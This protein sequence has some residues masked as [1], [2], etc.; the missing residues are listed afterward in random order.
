MKTKKTRNILIGA[1]VVLSTALMYVAWR[2]A[3]EPPPSASHIALMSQLAEQGQ[4]EHPDLIVYDGTNA[5]EDPFVTKEQLVEMG[6][7]VLQKDQKKKTG[8]GDLSKE[9]EEEI[10]KKLT[11]LHNEFVKKDGR[12]PRLSEVSFKYNEEYVLADYHGP[13]TVEALMAEF[14]EYYSHT[15]SSPGSE[16]DMLFPRDE[17]IQRALDL[18]VV[19]LDNYDYAGIMQVRGLIAWVQSDPKQ[20]ARLY[21]AKGL[22]DEANFNAYIDEK[23]KDEALNNILWRDAMRK[24]PNSTGGFRLGNRYV[25]TRDNHMHVK[26]MPGDP[27]HTVFMLGPRKRDLTDEEMHLLKY[28][29]VAPEDIEVFYID[30]NNEVMPPDSEPMRLDWKDRI[31]AMPEHKRQEEF[32]K[33]VEFLNSDMVNQMTIVDWMT[34][35]DYTGALLNYTD[36]GRAGV[37]DAPPVPPAPSGVAA[38][39]EGQA[40][41]PSEQELPRLLPPGVELP[42]SPGRSA[43]DV[44]AFF[45]FLDLHLIENAD[46][47]ENV[48]RGLKQR[49]E[50][51][52]MW[53]DQD[54]LR[55]QEPAPPSPPSNED[56]DTS[57]EDDED[58]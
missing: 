33:T 29:G 40:P 18:G 3:A 4:S 24:Y 36:G 5:D 15:H 14:D 51:Y 48:R 16:L 21:Q 23:I 41:P 9:A 49:Y 28:H 58:E 6:L 20:F 7:E 45:Q 54:R 25:M 27:D 26:I 55:R 1:A 12:P 53:K 17:W 13:Q 52:Q 2:R 8:T 38:P 10:R 32:R 37:S 39:S 47:P 46:V 19:F 35:A 43:E 57:D 42:E 50:A 11:D 44:D 30:E 31:A 34:M 56:G 22:E